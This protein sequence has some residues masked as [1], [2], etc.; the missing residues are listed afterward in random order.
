[1]YLITGAGGGVG[2]VSRCVVRLLRGA[3]EPVRAMVHREDGRAE[4]LRELGAEVVVGDLTNP[5][6]VVDAMQGTTRMFFNMSVSLDYLQA[7]AVVCAAVREA[8]GLQIVVNMS[9]MTVSEMI[10]T[11]CEESR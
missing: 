4:L 11:S 3:G 1:M 9:E 8:S 10:L 5:R 6:D 2:S 7:T